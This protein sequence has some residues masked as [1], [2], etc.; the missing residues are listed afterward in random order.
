MGYGSGI[1]TDRIYRIKTGTFGTGYFCLTSENIY[2]VSFGQ[3]TKKYH[4]IQ[5]SGV[6]GFI[7]AVL[8]G[9]SGER[10]KRQ[11]LQKDAF[12]I[13]PLQ[14]VQ[15]VQI[16]EPNDGPERVLLA[17]SRTTWNLFVVNDLSFTL[18]AINMARFDQL[19]DSITRV[20]ANDTATSVPAAKLQS[21]KKL[22]EAG[23]I[24]QNEYSEKKQEILSQ[25]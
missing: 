22:F 11:A 20:N 8:L 13:I 10:D 2:I 5:G 4:L 17:T 12:W 25:L 3:L 16:V 24:T 1:T 23:L 9:I 19:G 18:T 21:L 15:D 7:G 14:A 6:T